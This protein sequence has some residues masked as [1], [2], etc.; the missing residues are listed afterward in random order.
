MQMAHGQGEEVQRYESGF[1]YVRLPLQVG[2]QAGWRG[3][4]LCSSSE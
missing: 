3:S 1:V 4:K 2:E